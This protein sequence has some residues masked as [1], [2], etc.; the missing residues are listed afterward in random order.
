MDVTLEV[1]KLS[2][3]LNTDAPLNIWY[4]VV[5]LELF[6]L[7]MSASKFFKSL[8]SPLMSVMAETSHAAMGPYVAVAEAA[9]VL[10]AST[11]VVRSV[12]LV[13]MVL[14]RRRWWV[15]GMGMLVRSTGS[16]C[17]GHAT[18]WL[19]SASLL[20][21]GG[22]GGG[23]EGGGGEGGDGNGAGR[24]G[25]GGEGGCGDGGGG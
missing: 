12:L 23:S 8:K 5:T 14:S 2:G 6:Q 19:A 1:F 3:W 21:S 18:G 20:A 11:A 22:E 17:G 15:G 4:M 7:E 9:S 10:Y 13:K 25:G 16:H 24:L